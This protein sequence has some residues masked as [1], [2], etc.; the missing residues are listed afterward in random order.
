MKNY[1]KRIVLNGISC[2]IEVNSCPVQITVKCE[3]TQRCGHLPL[4]EFG[5]RNGINEFLFFTIKIHFIIFKKIN[6]SN[7]II[8]NFIF[9]LFNKKL[10]KI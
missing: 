1:Y 10:I 5:V 8:K 6:L 2:G 4:T 7:K 3:Q 9:I